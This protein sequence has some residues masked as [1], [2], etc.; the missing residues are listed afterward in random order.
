MPRRSIAALIPFIA[1]LLGASPLPPLPRPL[2]D[3]PGNIFVEGEEVTPPPATQPTRYFDYDNNEVQV[4]GKLPV[5]YYE[6]R[7][8]NGPRTTFGVVAPLKARASASSPISLD[9][10]MAWFYK[11][12]EQQHAA[13]SLL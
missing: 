1:I 9:V 4:P 11:T 5:G 13:I 2:P 8:E 7:P 10:G 3:H 6:A 12:S